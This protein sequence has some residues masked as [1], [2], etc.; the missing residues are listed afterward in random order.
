ML[1]LL[2]CVAGITITL[3]FII[4]FVK[5]SEVD[6]TANFAWGRFR[7]LNKKLFGDVPAEMIIGL[8]TRS[9]LNGGLF[10]ELKKVTDK[11]N[12]SFVNQINA[13][14]DYLKIEYVDEKKNINGREEQVFKGYRKKASK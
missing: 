10:Q 13:L 4:M 8:T 11:N 5:L 6:D 2:F 1:A 14:A 12:E 9:V 7:D 3:L